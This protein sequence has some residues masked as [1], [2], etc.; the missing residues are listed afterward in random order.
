MNDALTLLG[1]FLAGMALNLTPCVYPMFTITVS[2]F[3]RGEKTSF[4]LSFAKALTYVLGITVMY[5]VLGTVAAMTGGFFGSL[6]QSPWVRLLIAAVMFA[7]ALSMFGL[8]RLEA[9]GFI[10][11]KLGR[12]RVGFGGLFVS[13]LLV[14]IFAA[15]CIG[16]PVAALLAHVAERQDPVYGFWLFFTLASGLGFPYL[17]FGTFS[18]LLKALPKSGVWLVWVDRVFGVILL[19]FA[20]FYLTLALGSW[21]VLPARPVPAGQTAGQQESELAWQKYTPEVLKKA[22]HSG[23]PVIVDFYADWCLPCQE[24][25]R[26]TYRNPAV[27]EKMKRF[28]LVKVDLTDAGNE[29]EMALAETYAVYGI[30]T[31]LFFDAQ[32]K[33][34]KDLRGVGFIEPADFIRVLNQVPAQEP[35]EPPSN[36]AGS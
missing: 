36:K 17:V 29:P 28:E 9:P 20:V 13:G 7:M 15:P 21:G 14:G 12:K 22:T 23:R 3:S 35:T 31:L 2:I 30:P 27:V 33:E 16:P 18:N 32:G 24:M 25:E 19:G 5:S 4:A 11:E 10:L 6:L 8:F 26:V 34:L 1:I